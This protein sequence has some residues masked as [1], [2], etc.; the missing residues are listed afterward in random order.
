[1]SPNHVRSGVKA[2]R[3]SR[4]NGA[5]LPCRE[6]PVLCL[7]LFAF[8]FVPAVAGE[9]ALGRWLTEFMPHPGLIAMLCLAPLMVIL[10]IIEMLLGA[11]IWL[12]LMKRFVHQ[13][14]LATFFLGGPRVPVFS[15]LCSKIFAWSYGQNRPKTEL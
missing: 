1:M 11:T 6:H 5:R 15:S 2:D 9:V 4:E 14:I 10:F 7:S 13:N 8:M 12:L 3:N